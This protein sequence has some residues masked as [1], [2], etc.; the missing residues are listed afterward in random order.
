LA[1][2]GCEDAVLGERRFLS[3]YSKPVMVPRASVSKRRPPLASYSLI[4]RRRPSRRTL[5]TRFSAS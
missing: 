5:R 1:G 3:S 4:W 2:D